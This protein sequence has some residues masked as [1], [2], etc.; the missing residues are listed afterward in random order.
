M[1]QDLIEKYKKAFSWAEQYT[2][3]QHLRFSFSHFF[4]TSYV[5]YFNTYIITSAFLLAIQKRNF[6]KFVLKRQEGERNDNFVTPGRKLELHRKL[7]G[8]N[9]CLVGE[10]KL[11]QE[12]ENWI[13]KFLPNNLTM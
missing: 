11:T 12:I 10:K 8:Y 6:R 2:K 3:K 4:C 5:L 1:P 13:S 7:C 9:R